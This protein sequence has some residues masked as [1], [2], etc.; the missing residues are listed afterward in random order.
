MDWR[1][2][3][4]SPRFRNHKQQSP[5]CPGLAGGHPKQ[6]V[7]VENGCVC[8]RMWAGT[9]ETPHG[10]TLASSTLT[11]R[12]AL[13]L[14]SR[15]LA[16]PASIGGPLLHYIVDRLR[17]FINGEHT[18]D[19]FRRRYFVTATRPPKNFNHG[20]GQLWHNMMT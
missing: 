9:T 1:E 12:A 13:A 18:T 14:C 16:R 2:G 11:D 15:P 7:R 20:R 17:G 5:R 6:V 19:D 10:L 3:T 8:V 4:E